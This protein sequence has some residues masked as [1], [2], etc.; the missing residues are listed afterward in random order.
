MI[1]FIKFMA[2]SWAKDVVI[3]LLLVLPGDLLVTTLD[4]PTVWATVNGPTI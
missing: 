2:A 1:L 3:K 4:V